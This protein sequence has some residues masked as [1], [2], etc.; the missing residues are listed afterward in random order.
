MTDICF[1]VFFVVLQIEK[2]VTT[3]KLKYYFAVDTTYVG[4]KLGLLLFPY[5][6]SVRL[7]YI[8]C[9]SFVKKDFCTLSKGSV[10]ECSAT[11]VVSE[12]AVS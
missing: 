5:A 6:H 12:Q 4:K 8:C 2:Y 3:S 10:Q 11:L 1:V 7:F 9:Y